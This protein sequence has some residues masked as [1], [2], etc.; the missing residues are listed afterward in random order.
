MVALVVAV[1]YLITVVAMGYTPGAAL[2]WVMLGLVAL[3]ERS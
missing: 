1:P 3:S 2:G